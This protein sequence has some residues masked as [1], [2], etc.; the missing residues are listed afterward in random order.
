[1]ENKPYGIRGVLCVPDGNYYPNVFRYEQRIQSTLELRKTLRTSAEYDFQNQGIE[2]FHGRRQQLLLPRSDH[3]LCPEN[4]AAHESM[5]MESEPSQLMLFD[6]P[7]VDIKAKALGKP[8]TK[9]KAK[10][11]KETKQA[12][13]PVSSP[14]TP[15]RVS[16]GSSSGA[17]KDGDATDAVDADTLPMPS[18]ELDDDESDHKPLVDGEALVDGEGL[19]DEERKE[20]KGREKGKSGRGGGGS[21]L[22]KK[23]KPKRDNG[24]D[25][26]P[27][28]KQKGD[29]KEVKNAKKL[30]KSIKDVL[31]KYEMFKRL[32]AGKGTSKSMKD[33]SSSQ[34][35]KGFYFVCSLMIDS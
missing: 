27:P 10:Q 7:R 33:N 29:S 35:F 19:V 12:A 15:G 31:A 4:V 26:P 8:K 24:D 3:E 22:T 14:T 16:I 11:K 1:M 18:M 17:P 5:P 34:R 28:P 6:A 21:K 20:Q 30:T 9:P 13:E 2:E 23:G 32:F 25:L